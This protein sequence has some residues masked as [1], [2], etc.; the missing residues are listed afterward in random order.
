M[1][2]VR[3]KAQ[4]SMAMGTGKP[5]H[6]SQTQ[7]QRSESILLTSIPQIHFFKKSGGI[8][9]NSL[10]AGF[11]TLTSSQQ[12]SPKRARG[13]Y[14][15]HLSKRRT[16]EEEFP[17][18]LFTQPKCFHD[19][20]KSILLNKGQLQSSHTLITHSSCLRD[21]IYIMDLLLS[22]VILTRNNLPSPPVLKECKRP[23]LSK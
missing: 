3:R 19:A 12:S 11:R 8:E 14:L 22:S 6:C 9:I 7:Q 20:K 18:N 17:I 16:A 15:K 13:D 5:S 10:F 4:Q 1:K 2:Y 21:S 23:S